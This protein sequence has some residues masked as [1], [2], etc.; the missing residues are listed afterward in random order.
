[1]FLEDGR[2]FL[3]AARRRKGNASSH[4]DITMS[5]ST[6]AGARYAP[7]FMGKLRANFI[8]TEFVLLDNGAKPSSTGGSSGGGP[9]V[10]GGGGGS[11]GM[12]GSAG[13]AGAAPRRELAAV[14]FE[15]NILG[16]KGPRKMTVALP[17]VPEQ[18]RGQAA[19]QQ[20]SGWA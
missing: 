4:Y 6:G 20:V 12:V 3:L 16:T 8:G 7:G 9:S 17:A 10:S 1:M 13:G 11:V 14:T 2:R 19:Q 18:G 15:P 5:Q